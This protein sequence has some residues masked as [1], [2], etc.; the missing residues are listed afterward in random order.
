MSSD[1]IAEWINY[2]WR[3][4]Q[5]IFIN[6]NWICM[7]FCDIIISIFNYLD[8]SEELWPI[9][10]I[11]QIPKEMGTKRSICFYRHYYLF[12]DPYKGPLLYRIFSS[13]IRD[14]LMSGALC[15]NLRMRW[16]S[17]REMIQVPPNLWKDTLEHCS[18]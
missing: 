5:Y 7:I 9:Q 3:F 17:G 8:I 13:I 18:T 11:V 15:W 12:H 2:N 10:I 1:L 6:V 16:L 4:K 14:K